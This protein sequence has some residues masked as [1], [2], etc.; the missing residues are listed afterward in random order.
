MYTFQRLAGIAAA[1]REGIYQNTHP[2]GQWRLKVG[3]KCVNGNIDNGNPD[4]NVSAYA[5]GLWGR[6]LKKKI[7][8]RFNP[9][10]ET[11]YPKYKSASLE[12]SVKLECLYTHETQVEKNEKGKE[13][14]K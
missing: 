5:L 4:T 10:G 9:S 1:R 6:G 7:N 8:Y 14:R 11:T 3:D 2:Y 13:K 12:R